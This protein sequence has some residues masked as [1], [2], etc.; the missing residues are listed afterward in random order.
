MAPGQCCVAGGTCT[1]CARGDEATWAW[2][3]I[4][5]RRCKNLAT[6]SPTGTPAESTP[7]PTGTDAPTRLTP[8]PTAVPAMPPQSEKPTQTPTM[9]PGQCC[10]AGGTCTACARGDEATWAWECI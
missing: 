6:Q 5:S 9:A 10:V 7:A 1:A 4:T 2:E 3:C 8:I